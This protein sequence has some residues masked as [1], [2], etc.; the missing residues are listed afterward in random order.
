MDTVISFVGPLDFEPLS[1]EVVD[2]LS[3]SD[4]LPGPR[5]SAQRETEQGGWA[6]AHVAPTL[7]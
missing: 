4:F 3:G 5:W 2:K 6:W 7:P 1:S